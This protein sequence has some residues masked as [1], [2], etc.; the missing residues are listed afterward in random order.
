MDYRRI[1]NARAFNRHVG[2]RL[3]LPI[4]VTLTCAAPSMP[5]LFL[6]P[7]SI[8]AFVIW[9]NAGSRRFTRS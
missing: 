4:I 5:L 9:V 8:L 7:L 2:T 1:G 3:L 6:L